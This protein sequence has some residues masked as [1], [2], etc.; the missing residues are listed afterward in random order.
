M[1]HDHR[2]TTR[3]GAPRQSAECPEPSF[4]S[5]CE[6]VRDL[7]DE[8]AADK[9]Y[10]RTGLSGP[11]PLY[12]L[13]NEIA[14]GPGHAL[15]EIVYKAIRYSKRRD[16]SDLAKSSAWAFLIWR[17]DRPVSARMPAEGNHP[18]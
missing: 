12:A 11:N 15:G 3:D 14:N 17:F 7:L 9:G 13:V 4:L 1:S 16:P 2:C 6:A 5:F 18:R 10:Q 8:T